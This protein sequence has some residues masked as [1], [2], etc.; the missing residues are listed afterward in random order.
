MPARERSTSVTVQKTIIMKEVCIA[1]NEAVEKQPNKMA[2]QYKLEFNIHMDLDPL[3]QE[4]L[5]L[6]WN[7]LIR[8]T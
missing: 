8:F 5:Q 1:L 4:L 2:Y 7:K 6:N 3:T